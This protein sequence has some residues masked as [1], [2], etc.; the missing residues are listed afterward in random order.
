MSLKDFY[1]KAVVKKL[2]AE[3]GDKNIHSLPKIIKVVVNVGFGKLTKEPKI[4]E[5]IEG[6]LKRITGQKPLWSKAKKS[7][8]DFKI[9]KGQ[10]I[11]A[12]VTLRGKRMYDFLEKLIKAALPRVRDFR[13]LSLK[14]L[15]DKGNLTIGFKEHLAFPEIKSDEV[16]RIHG[17]EVSIIT[18]AK[19][20][21]EAEKLF[22]YFG[23]P[24]RKN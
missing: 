11:G 6:T 24:L 19:N 5:T 17:L 14:A 9:R 10:I 18:S 2:T 12:K 20:K 1:Q 3:M 21:E 23:F 8:S 15:D 22:F 16:E 7:I 13:G 4:V